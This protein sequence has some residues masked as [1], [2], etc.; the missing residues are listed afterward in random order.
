MKLSIR[1]FRAGQ[2]ARRRA[3]R[4]TAAAPALLAACLL[5]ACAGDPNAH[6]DAMAQPAGLQRAQVQAGIFVL[7]SYSRIAR[8]D[9][10]LT[11]YIEG[12]GL[13]W[14]SRYQ[15]SDDPSP[16]NAL[17]LGLA[18]ADASPNVLYLARPCQFTP[19]AANPRCAV[20]YW[21]DRRYS[22]EVVAS[23]NAAVTQYMRRLPG[24]RVNLVGYSG[25]GAVAVLIAARR[26]DVATLR[27]VAGN[28]DHTAVNRLHQV[29]PM[30][31]SLNAIDVAR[32]IA[33]I[34]QLHISGADDKVVPASIARA[35]AAA[36]G[37][38]ARLRV[39]DGMAHES[40]WPAK[41]PGLLSIPLSCP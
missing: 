34:P 33:A 1:I 12:D 31:D 19:M 5:T 11:V 29:S 18:V 36:V 21:T 24:Q 27:T 16:H 4:R 30:P 15:P 35:F 7:T 20:T 13:A 10:P 26:E 14:R 8:P 17:G 2:A 38:C 41:W 28:L 23:M 40:D 37:P 39:V 25:G 9:K 32:Q 6:A 3:T 22:E